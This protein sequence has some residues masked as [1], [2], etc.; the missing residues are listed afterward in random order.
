MGQGAE[1]ASGGVFERATSEIVSSPT[2]QNTQRLLVLFDFREGPKAQDTQRKAPPGSA[3]EGAAARAN[4]N[5]QCNG[6]RFEQQL[7]EIADFVYRK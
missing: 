5:K 2:G 6:G 7:Y 3:V 1:T 4:A